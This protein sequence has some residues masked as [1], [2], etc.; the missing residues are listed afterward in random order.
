METWELMTEIEKRTPLAEIV[1]MTQS[2]VEDLVKRHR[3]VLWETEGQTCAGL[4]FV[5][6][7][8]LLAKAESETKSIRGKGRVGILAKPGRADE[9]DEAGVPVAE[10]KPRNMPPGHGPRESALEIAWAERGTAETWARERSAQN[11]R[12]RQAALDKHI[13]ELAELGR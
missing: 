3:R 13:R 10:A 6:A 7:G 2:E 4:S 5:I 9:F 12:L 1:R 8:Q 11:Q